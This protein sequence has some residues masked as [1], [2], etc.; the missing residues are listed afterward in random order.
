MIRTSCVIIAL[1]F[2]FSFYKW[3]STFGNDM[4][5]SI[6]D[7]FIILRTWEVWGTWIERAGAYAK[8]KEV[9]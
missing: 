9:L 4:S 1:F 7:A 3:I 2:P 5:A 6:L 8:A